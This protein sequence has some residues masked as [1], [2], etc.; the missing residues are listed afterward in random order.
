MQTTPITSSDPAPYVISVCTE[1]ESSDEQVSLKVYDLLVVIISCD[2]K[3][4]TTADDDCYNTIVLI[5]M[6][7]AD[8]R[9]MHE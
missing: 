4:A 3:Q 2:V 9:M 6:K 8:S 5:V 7:H 1:D